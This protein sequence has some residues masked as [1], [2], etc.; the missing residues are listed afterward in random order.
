MN[1]KL[2]KTICNI[3]DYIDS[4]IQRASE[5]GKPVFEETIEMTKALA[6]LVSAK[7]V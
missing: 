7:A 1:E 4:D 5:N 6:E 2:E 3:C